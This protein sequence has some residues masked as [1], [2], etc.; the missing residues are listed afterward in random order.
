MQISIFKKSAQQNLFI[1]FSKR[2]KGFWKKKQ[3][4]GKNYSFK[5]YDP[6]DIFGEDSGFEQFYLVGDNWVDKPHAPII[7]AVGFNDW[8]FGFIADYLKEYRIAFSPRKVTNLKLAF[9]MSK[10]I[11]KPN[12]VIVWG[13]NESPWLNRYLAY[14]HIDVW[15]VEDGFLRSS[16]LG[17]SGSTPYSLV[18]DK[19]GLYYNTDGSSELNEILNKQKFENLLRQGEELYNFFLNSK[20]SKYNPSVTKKDTSIK[21][22]RRVLVIGQVDNDA[23]LRFCNIDNWSMEDMV[24]LAKKENPQAEIVYRPHPEVYKGYQNSKFD[25]SNVEFFATIQNPELDIISSIEKSDHIYTI[26][27]LGGLE[28]LIRG[29]KVTL[30]GRAFY[31]GWGLTDDRTSYINRDRSLTLLELFLGT[32]V[33]YPKYLCDSSNSYNGLLS[34][35]YRVNADKYIHTLSSVKQSGVDRI[36]VLNWKFESYIWPALLNDASQSLDESY[37]FEVLKKV[38][39]IDYYTDSALSQKILSYFLLGKAFNNDVKSRVLLILREHI[40]ENVYNGLLLDLH[41]FGY[42]DFLDIHWLWLLDHNDEDSSLAKVSVLKNLKYDELRDVALSIDEKEYDSNF[43][44]E[45]VKDTLNEEVQVLEKPSDIKVDKLSKMIGEDA[46]EARFDSKPQT[47]PRVKRIQKASE[48]IF[49]QINIDLTAKRYDSALESILKLLFVGYSTIKLLPVLCRLLNLMALPNELA[50]VSSLYKGLNIFSANRSPIVQEMSAKK[51]NGF[52]N[53]YEL[54]EFLTK[55]IYLKPNLIANAKILLANNL[56]DTSKFTL[57][58]RLVENQL[59]FDNDISDRKIQAYIGIGEFRKAELTALRLLDFDKSI[60]S[61]FHYSQTLSYLNRI[62]EAIKLMSD[63]LSI[64]YSLVNVQELLR[65][66]IIAAEYDEALKLVKK[67]QGKGL[68][69]GDMYLRKIYFGSRM[70]KDAFLSF[71]DMKVVDHMKNYYRNKYYDTR[72][73][74]NREFDSIF[75]IAVFGPGDEIRFSSIYSFI[76]R[77]FYNKKV[78][79]SCSPNLQKIFSDSFPGLEFVG[80]NRLRSTD[81]VNLESYTNVPGSD[82]FNFVDNKAVEII[83]KVDKIA[84]TTDF[85]HLA[86]PDYESFHGNKYLDYDANFKNI[87]MNKLPKDEV[88]VGLSWRSSLSTTARNEHYL[89]VEEMEP[90]FSINNVRYVNLQYD[91]CDEELE[92]INSRYPGKILNFEDLDQYNDFDNVAALMSCM[93]LIIAPATT[94]VE[95][96][97]ALGINTWLFSNSAEIDWRIID[98]MGTDVWHNSIHIVDVPEKGNKQALVKEIHNRLTKFVESEI[99]IT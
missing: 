34:S 67:A 18:F 83:N 94:V 70:V 29:K 73:N 27:S 49:S 21:T 7:I 77:F 30:L 76:K 17:A 50:I 82:I 89:S 71:T 62:D 36:S 63:S 68:K 64:E 38:N 66:Y 24:R 5:T 41:H 44:F 55:L 58:D 81:T 52:E 48:T 87:F 15:R 93:Q 51:I 8:K 22:K 88:L 1:Y 25:K 3:L 23:S 96:A 26:C 40:S 98:E 47:N 2:I 79:I 35:I 75:L 45:T 56:N 84:L 61:Q 72:N 46:N 60:R 13:Y 59:W 32:Y 12:N 9:R 53:D 20:V 74:E 85:L 90:L 78:Y 97:G 95:L 14:N 6:F 43:N 42:S 16:E 86:L 65:L 19:K 10:L 39:L 99:T 92:W 11:Y 31:G 37:F 80:V 57:Y 91:E 69:I 4:L 33:I 54:V 28:A